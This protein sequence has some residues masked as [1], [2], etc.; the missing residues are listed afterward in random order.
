[1]WSGT[2]LE[3]VCSI[4]IWPGSAGLSGSIGAGR[5]PQPLYSNLTGLKLSFSLE[6][7]LG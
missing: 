3:R 7:D 2:T 4:R 1:M 5:V 6:I